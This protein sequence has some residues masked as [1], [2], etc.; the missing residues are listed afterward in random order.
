MTLSIR[1]RWLIMFVVSGWPAALWAQ[2]QEAATGGPTTLVVKKA[3]FKIEVSASGVFEA[4]EMAAVRLDTEEWSTL[5]VEEAVP[6]G[7][8][9]KAG[10]VLIRFKLD[11]LERAVREQEEAQVLAELA[12]QQARHDLQA[13]E[14]SLQDELAAAERTRADLETDVQRFLTIERP[15]LQRT[16]ENNLRTAE[17]YLE[18]AQEELRQLEKMYKADD[19]TEETEEIILKRAQRDVEQAEFYLEQTRL[20]TERTLQIDL[21]RQEISLQDA[22]R[23]AKLAWEKARLELPAAVTRARL[24]LEKQQHE[25]QQGAEKLEKLR[26]DRERLVVRSPSDGIV[27]YGQCTRGRWSSTQASEGRYEKGASVTA[28]TV[29]MTVVQPRPLRVRASLNEKDLQG[30]AEGA[31]GRAVCTAFPS[32]AVAVRLESLAGVPTAEGT[33]DVALSAELASDL[34]RLLPGMTCSIT[35]TA[36]YRGDAIS[37]PTSAVFT[38][39]EGE[40]YVYRVG[41]DGAHQRCK[42]TLGPRTEERVEILEGLL[43][44]DIILLSKPE[45]EA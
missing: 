32:A 41:A 6:H 20:Q 24:A 23:R 19:L 27:Y 34:P 16:A 1:V 29:L 35:L 9:V 25:F 13:L 42:V 4:R 12:L 8:S 40:A 21:P 18:Y 45:G 30:L 43:E 22:L 44:G 15:M 17:F 31:S 2:Q 7:T 36:Y 14:S 26:R 33:Y 5:V 3:P 38:G 10:E 39:D 37:V 11:E 28:K